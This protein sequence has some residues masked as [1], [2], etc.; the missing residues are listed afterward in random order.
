MYAQVPEEDA[1]VF[2]L[3]KTEMKTCIY[4]QDWERFLEEY[5]MKTGEIVIFNMPENAAFSM[6]V[7][8]CDEKCKH[9]AKV[10]VQQENA[11][12]DDTLTGY[13]SEDL[14]EGIDF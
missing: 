2:S 9:K 5:S 13:D 11:V 1:Y 3:E 8:P 4:G 12:S 6:E 7:T 10:V 14:E